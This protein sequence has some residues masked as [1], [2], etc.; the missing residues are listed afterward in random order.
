MFI[1]LYTLYYRHLYFLPKSVFYGFK[2][3][4]LHFPHSSIVCMD[5]RSITSRTFNL[6]IEFKEDS[7]K[8]T[9]TYEFE[10]L[11]KEE[12]ENI[13]GYIKKVG[14]QFGTEERGTAPGTSSSNENGAADQKDGSSNSLDGSPDGSDNDEEEKMDRKGKSKGKAADMLMDDDDEGDEDYDSED[15]ENDD[16]E[17]VCIVF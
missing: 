16:D 9:T 5:V 2:K 3:P 10:M 1:P 17:D 14:I 12:F 8:T 11:A 6:L 15:A 4:V 7:S 13:M